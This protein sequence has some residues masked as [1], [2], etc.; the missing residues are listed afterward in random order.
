MGGG[1]GSSP[2]TP[3]YKGAA[4]EQ[5]EQ[6]R[7]TFLEGLDAT[8]INQS[9]PF[10]SQTWEWTGPDRG[11]APDLDTYLAKVGQG[12]QSAENAILSSGG[13]VSAPTPIFSDA[14]GERTEI[15]G[16]RAGVGGTAGGG[17]TEAQARKD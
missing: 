5:G 3:D 2:K 1:K 17:Y 7:Q 6:N 15:G 13:R 10:G 4:K 16:W 11:P 12:N 14:T 9:N 8:R